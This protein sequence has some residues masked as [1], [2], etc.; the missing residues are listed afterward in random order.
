MKAL[1]KLPPLRCARQSGIVPEKLYANGIWFLI[2]K[3]I[4]EHPVQLGVV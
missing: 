4:N 1:F 2:P 3:H